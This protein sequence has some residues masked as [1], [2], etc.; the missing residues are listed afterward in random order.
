MIDEVR[1]WDRAL[2]QEEITTRSTYNTTLNITQ[3]LNLSGYWKMDCANPLTNEV[4]GQ[5]DV[6]GGGVINYNENFNNNLCET[7]IEYDY[8]CP[9][10]FSGQ[11]D[12]NSCDPP[13]GV[14]M[15]GR[16]ITII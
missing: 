9:V 3:E 15:R 8:D 11:T 13:E 4:T 7:V 1:I 12:C 6:E 2:S 5:E 14:L 10:D 16:V